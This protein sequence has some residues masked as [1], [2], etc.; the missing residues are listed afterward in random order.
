MNMRL[1]QDNNNMGIGGSGGRVVNSNNLGMGNDGG[2]GAAH[3]QMVHF[4][5]YLGG[6]S[7]ILN[8]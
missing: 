3:F 1:R 4:L 7:L 2:S 8:V 6:S 5:F